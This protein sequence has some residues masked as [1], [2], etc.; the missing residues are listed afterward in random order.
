MIRWLKAGLFDGASMSE[1]AE[2]VV[3]PSTPPP[4]HPLPIPYF[5]A[6]K[7]TNSLSQQRRLGQSLD[8]LDK[9]DDGSPTVLG[10]A[11]TWVSSRRWE[12]VGSLC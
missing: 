9:L 6:E 3:M 1:A 4:P 8:S 5:R 12:P 11:D 7:L 10:E 2:V